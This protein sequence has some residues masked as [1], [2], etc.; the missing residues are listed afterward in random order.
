[1][2]K[3]GDV[4]ED[5]YVFKSMYTD[6]KGK[7]KEHWISPSTFSAW[8][9]KRNECNRKNYELNIEKEKLRGKEYRSKNK[10]KGSARWAKYKAKKLKATPTWLTEKHFKEIEQIYLLAK[11]M[12][13][14][15]NDKFEVDHIEPLQGKDVCGLHV[16]W[17][18]RVI[19]MQENRKKGINREFY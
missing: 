12:S 3:Q 1:M 8:K 5:G 17:N 14:T 10:E 6:K 19:T 4:R 7:V 18:L 13:E 16:P 2:H 15:L 9:E 11:R